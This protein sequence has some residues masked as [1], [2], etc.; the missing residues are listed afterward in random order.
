MFI[1]FIPFWQQPLLQ[2]DTRLILHKLIA[3]S[4]GVVRRQHRIG[5]GIGKPLIGNSPASLPHGK[6]ADIT[7]FL[8]GNHRPSLPHRESPV[9]RV[10]QRHRKAVPPPVGDGLQIPYGVVQPAAKAAQDYRPFA[11][12]FQGVP[13]GQNQVGII[14]AHGINDLLQLPHLLQGAGIKVPHQYIGDDARCLCPQVSPVGADYQVRFLRLLRR[15]PAV[16][17]RRRA[18]N[19]RRAPFYVLHCSFLSHSLMFLALSYMAQ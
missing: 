4:Q 18:E 1:S 15:Q 9:S 11:S 17:L 12:P 13:Q 10:H 16:P 8:P 14:L 2:G 5:Q 6:K 7:V 19:Q 3:D